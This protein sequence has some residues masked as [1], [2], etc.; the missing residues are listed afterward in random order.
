ME[1]NSSQ[2]F[3]VKEH[4][5]CAQ[6]KEPKKLCDKIIQYYGKKDFRPQETKSKN[7]ANT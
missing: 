5:K 2:V 1:R 6:N 4:L 7:K 3:G